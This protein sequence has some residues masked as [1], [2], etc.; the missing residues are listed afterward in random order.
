MKVIFIED[1]IN[2][3]NAGEVR[4][5]ANGYARNYLFPKQ[6][7]VAAT[8]AELKKFESQRKKYA[9]RQ[10]RQEQEASVLAEKL[11]DL[12]IVIRAKAGEKGRI[13]GSVTNTD[14]AAEIKN[15]SG[16]EIDKRRI[17]LP[18]SIREIGGYQVTIKFTKDIK[19]RINVDVEQEQTGPAVVQ[20]KQEPEKSHIQEPVVEE[21]LEEESKEEQPILEV[22]SAVEEEPQEI[23][24]EEAEEHQKEE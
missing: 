5:V 22:A 7:A 18:E 16:Y 23:I 3:A 6:L 24:E 21:I 11:D 20:D 14:I 15:V 4:D 12:S 10:A 13:Y 1:V 9:Q 17:E 8:P 2:V 19:A